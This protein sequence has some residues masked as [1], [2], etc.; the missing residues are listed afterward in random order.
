MKIVD[1]ARLHVLRCPAGGMQLKAFHLRP[2]DEVDQRDAECE[3]V[4]PGRGKAPMMD[5]MAKSDQLV[6]KFQGLLVEFNFAGIDDEG[7][8]LTFTEEQLRWIMN[9]DETE[10][11]LNGDTH[12]GGRPSVA[13]YDPHLSIASRSVAKSPLACTGI[14]GSNL[15]VSACHRTFSFQRVRR[16]RRERR[17]GTRF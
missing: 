13:F 1:N 2:C 12:V 8:E 16:P 5:N 3:C 14:F 10:L 17:S 6:R 9:I 11:A 4:A 15:S 7:G